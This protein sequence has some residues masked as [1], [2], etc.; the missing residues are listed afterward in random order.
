[1]AG[2]CANQ[3]FSCAGQMD[4]KR[5]ALRQFGLPTASAFRAVQC[6]QPIEVTDTM[7]SRMKFLFKVKSYGNAGGFVHES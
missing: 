2:T 1:M 4:E 6:T 7:A 3:I 5:Q